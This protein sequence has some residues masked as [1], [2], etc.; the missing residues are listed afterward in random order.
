M[1]DES[2]GDARD[3]GTA[4]PETDQQVHGGA[5]GD[6]REQRPKL[7][8]SRKLRITLTKF[9]ATSFAATITSQLVVTILFWTHLTTAGIAT[10]ISFLAGSLVTYFVNRRWTWGRRGKA[11]FRTEVLPYVAVIAVY[12]IGTV[13]FT[14]LVH[15]MIAPLVEGT[16]LRGIALNASLLT[17]NALLLALKFVGLD[18]VFG[19]R[20]AAR[21]PAPTS[22]S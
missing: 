9:A 12:G 21:T 13:G 15:M 17:A 8:I 6:A 3:A 7:R 14:K 20:H 16:S 18:R 22:Q 1:A 5:Q 10:A 11:K 4:T 19:D 2:A